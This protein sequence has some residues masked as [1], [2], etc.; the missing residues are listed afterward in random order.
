MGVDGV[1]DLKREVL[2][3]SLGTCCVG[4]NLDRAAFC[5]YLNLDEQRMSPLFIEETLSGIPAAWM[6]DLSMN[7]PSNEIDAIPNLIHPHNLVNSEF[8]LFLL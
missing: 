7:P 8:L 4:H 3:L 5:I 1:A 6:N 2:R